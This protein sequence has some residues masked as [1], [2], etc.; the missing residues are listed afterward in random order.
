[1]YQDDVPLIADYARSPEGLADVIVFALL[2]VRTQ[3][4][5]L[6]RQMADI[7]RNGE[8]SSYLW[9][10]KLQGY[11]DVQR[12]ASFLSMYLPTADDGLAM[13]QL[14]YTIKGL[15]CAKAGFVLQMLGRDVACFDSRNM[16]KLGLASDRPWRLDDVSQKTQ[17]K[18]IDRYIKATRDS[19]GAEYW[20]NDWCARVGADTG[21]TADQIS[22]LHSKTIIRK[23]R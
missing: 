18:R 4:I 19:G 6:P 7:R 3:F 21:N 20:W 15:G 12:Q 5:T 10:W 13:F 14:H 1:M 11:Q 16:S 22:R 8:R 17:I 23:G 9:G 2:S